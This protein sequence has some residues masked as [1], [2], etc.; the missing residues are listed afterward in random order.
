MLKKAQE[1]VKKLRDDIALAARETPQVLFNMLL[2]IFCLIDQQRELR[3]PSID[4]T[5]H[6]EEPVSDQLEATNLNTELDD[7]LEKEKQLM[8]KL[9]NTL[10]Q[11]K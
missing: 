5:Y 8:D 1:E 4:D 11:L 9:V 6:Q 10:N 3:S 7:S 2:I